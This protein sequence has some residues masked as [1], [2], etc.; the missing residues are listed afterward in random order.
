[1]KS[2]ITLLA[3]SLLLVFTLTACGGGGTQTGANDQ[4]NT[5]V[6]GG[7]NQDVN[8]G[9]LTDP[10][11]GL[12]GGAGDGQNN[13][14]A[15]NPQNGTNGTAG[16]QNNTGNTGSGKGNGSLAGDAKDA[17]DDVGNALTD[18]GDAVRQSFRGSGFDQMVRNARVHDQD[19]DLMDGE[20]RAT[21]GSTF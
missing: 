4:N 10:N 5:G 21:P 11:G 18:G 9:G 14:T 17:L 2:T 16:A 6:T 20:N 3:A 19:G 15:G 8:G 7:T 12:T 13:S 1:M